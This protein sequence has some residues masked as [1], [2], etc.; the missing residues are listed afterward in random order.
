M[1]RVLVLSRWNKFLQ[2]E[3]ISYPILSRLMVI[4]MA[5]N[6]NSSRLQSL[7][8][9]L[10]ICLDS[11]TI[12]NPIIP[13]LILALI[14][15]IPIIPAKQAQ[16]IQ[17]DVVLWL[18]YMTKTM[19]GE[20]KRT[21]KLAQIRILLTDRNS[22]N[23]WILRHRKEQMTLNRTT[24]GKTSISNCTK[25]ILICKRNYRLRT[26]RC[27]NCKTPLIFKPRILGKLRSRTS[28][29]TPATMDY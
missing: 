28:N 13:S 5:T 19:K 17:Q 29:W 18:I 1:D 10:R 22:R 11:I 24:S 25:V 8:S 20:D 26:D 4:I 27:I 6:L 21:N 7:S 16:T 12:V 3:K 23:S 15:Q 14:I 2:F 9:S